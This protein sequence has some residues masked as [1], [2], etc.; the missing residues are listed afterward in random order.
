MN[1]FCNKDSSL[2]TN[3]KKPLELIL[4]EAGLISIGQVELALQEQ[5]N[6]DFKFGEIL[7]LHGWIKQETVDFFIYQWPKL[8]QKKEKKPLV[9][10]FK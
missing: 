5:K 6:H 8:I 9:Y 1:D 3:S 7:A 4:V 2:L 10:Y